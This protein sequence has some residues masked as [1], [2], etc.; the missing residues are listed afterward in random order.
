MQA[1]GVLGGPWSPYELPLPLR[2]GG[3]SSTFASTTFLFKE[4]EFLKAGWWFFF[5]QS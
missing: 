2:P 4:N 5:K 1:P 3:G